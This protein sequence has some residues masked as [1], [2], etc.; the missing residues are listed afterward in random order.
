[1]QEVKELLD[2]LNNIREQ[3][4]ELQKQIEAQKE[5]ESQMGKPL[6]LNKINMSNELLGCRDY[7]DHL[8]KKQNLLAVEKAK[9]LAQLKGPIP[10]L[11]EDLKAE[12]DAIFDA[13][14]GKIT[15]SFQEIC[16]VKP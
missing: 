4:M 16:T 5:R 13:M 10:D 3:K 2:C 8:Q 11:E 14:L 7:L 1:M 12:I 6:S 9:I 15:V